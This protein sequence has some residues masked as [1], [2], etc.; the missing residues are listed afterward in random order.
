MLVLDG[1]P[2]ELD[3]HLS[4]LATSLAELYGLPLP[5]DAA[6]LATDR[7]AGVAQGRLRLTVAPGRTTVAEAESSRPPHR[8]GV[9]LRS[10][11]LP[12][13]LGA[14][15]WADRSA[16]P[17]ENGEVALLLDTGGEVLEAAWAN[18]FVA[19]ENVLS[20]PPLDGRILPGVTRAAAIEIASGEGIEVRE[21][22]LQRD[23]L[24]AA[25]E[26]FLTSSVRGVEPARTLDGIS[27]GAAARIAERLASA[28]ERRRSGEPAA[29]W[30]GRSLAAR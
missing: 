14:H 29:P 25:E 9:A 19:H 11:P 3:A 13:G 18:V 21:R 27:L 2:V 20:T 17:A 24:L 30:G 15:K 22:P 4:R 8:R 23:D 26:V 7:A 16:L 28:L 10:H 5:R 1:E 12:G 6:E